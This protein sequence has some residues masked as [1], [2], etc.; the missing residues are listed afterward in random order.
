MALTTRTRATTLLVTHR[1]EEAVQLADRLFFLSDRPAH[2]ILEKALLLPR[3]ARS[4]D[5]IASIS[6]ELRTL[7]AR[8]ATG[9]G[10]S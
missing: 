8:A 1:L 7:V 5:V 4:K 3:K 2:I 10:Q 6:E 9:T